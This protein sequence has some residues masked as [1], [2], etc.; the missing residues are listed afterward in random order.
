MKYRA[1]KGDDVTRRFRRAVHTLSRIHV[2][3]LNGGQEKYIHQ[4]MIHERGNG[5]GNNGRGIRT[6][7]SLSL[8]A[9]TTNDTTHVTFESDSVEKRKDVQSSL[10]DIIRNRLPYI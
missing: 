5:N 9:S 10:L 7:F 3:G 2:Q 1:D 6:F 4:R 8:R